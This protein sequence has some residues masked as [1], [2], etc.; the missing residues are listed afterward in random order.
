MSLRSYSR[1]DY[2]GG[3]SRNNDRETVLLFLWMEL[4]YERRVTKVHGYQLSM[5]LP[6]NS[7]FK[8]NL[9]GPGYVVCKSASNSIAGTTNLESGAERVT[10]LVREPWG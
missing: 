5:D 4:T 1:A 2:E 6:G 9:Y 3:F 8:I 7:H 10:Q